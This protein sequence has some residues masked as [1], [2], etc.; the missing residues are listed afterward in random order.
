[1]PAPY[2]ELAQK[3]DHDYRAQVSYDTFKANQER[4]S[5]AVQSQIQAG[6]LRITLSDEAYFYT[7]VNYTG[8][9]HPMQQLKPKALENLKEYR[10]FFESINDT[11]IDRFKEKGTPEQN[12]MYD[13]LKSIQKELGRSNTSTV[14]SEEVAI[15]AYNLNRQLDSLTAEN[16]GKSIVDPLGALGRDTWNII[17]YPANEIVTGNIDYYYQLVPYHLLDYLNGKTGTV[18][19]SP[20]TYDH[21]LQQLR[22]EE[23]IIT[24][25]AAEEVAVSSEQTISSDEETEKPLEVHQGQDVSEQQ[26]KREDV[27]TQGLFTARS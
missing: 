3:A 18:E 16:W 14:F 5:E 22:N 6:A 21:I 24:P 26:K 2:L 12:Q 17:S 10:T 27:S 11:N 9:S 25:E 13:I 20:E 7:L 23:V 8:W 19:I 4:L 15:S 1:M